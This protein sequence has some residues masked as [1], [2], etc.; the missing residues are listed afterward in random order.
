MTAEAA[1]SGAAFDNPLMPNARLRQMYLAMLKAR[2]VARLLPGR[3]GDGSAAGLEACLV[4]P[5]VDLGPGDLVSDVLNGGAVDF[6]RGATLAAVL[7]PKLAP[8][9]RG[10]RADCGKAARLINPIDISERVWSALGA[11]AALKAF[12]PHTKAHAAP[13]I[14]AQQAGVVVFYL[15]PNQLPTPLLRKALT[16]AREKALPVLFVVLPASPPN[17]GKGTTSSLSPIALRCGVPGMLVDA[18]DAVAIY[19]VAQEAI[20]HARIGGGP[21][22]I[23]TMQFVVEG[24]KKRGPVHDAVS[25]LEQYILQRRVATRAWMDREAASFAKQAAAAKAASK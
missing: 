5:T 11:A 17:D 19:R 23:E 16:F 21:A 24:G 3:R 20:G 14:E 18:Q 12:A 4:S 8:K 9:K 22:L 6:L 10:E 2:T 7:Q 25:G 1:D 15:L 13:N